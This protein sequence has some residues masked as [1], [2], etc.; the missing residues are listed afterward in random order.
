MADWQQGDG[1]FIEI[2]DR[3]LAVR[4]WGPSPGT[5]PVLLLL[6]EGLGCVE[7]WKTFPKA[8]H[9]ATGLSVVA[10]SRTG[11]GR[12]SAAA[13]PRPLDYMEREA[14]DV[15][16]AV[17]AALN[18]EK[19]I[20]IGHSDGAS[21]A[22]VL[23]GLADSRVRGLCLIAPHF[24]AE[25]SGLDA[26]ATT[27]KSY[28]TGDLRARLAKYHNDPDNA[29]FGWADA[30]LH[31]DFR[32]WDIQDYLPGVQ[33][34]VLAI[35]GVQDAYG[36]KAQIKALRDGLL[37][38]FDSLMVENCGHAPHLE[39]QELVVRK[40]TEFLNRLQRIEDVNVNMQYN[41]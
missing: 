4:C 39:H 40:L 25:D 9:L 24:F 41:A 18:L 10:Y 19:A 27:R 38:P 26:I 31:P 13:L 32:N 2:A 29:F 34:P 15:L 28:V 1:F 5:T 36:T 33:V 17:L 7:L 35:Q 22:A 8:L 23:G 30:W 20:L 6:H 12:S 21:I 3:K 16:P 14:L 11:Y 37:A